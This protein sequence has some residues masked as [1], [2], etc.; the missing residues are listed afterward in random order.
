MTKEELNFVIKDLK[1][2]P[3]GIKETCIT[4]RQYLKN[5]ELNEKNITSIDSPKSIIEAKEFIKAVNLLMAYAWQNRAND[6]IPELYYC[7]DDCSFIDN[8][9]LCPGECQLA[10]KDENGNSLSKKRCPYYRDSSYI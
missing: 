3:R 5:C 8:Y 7:E 4:A 9:L 1:C 10:S 6:C 2:I